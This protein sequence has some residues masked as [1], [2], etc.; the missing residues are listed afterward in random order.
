MGIGATY[1]VTFCH[2]RL[3]WVQTISS[4]YIAFNHYTPELQVEKGPRIYC[5]M[6]NIVELNSKAQVDNFTDSSSRRFRIM[7]RDSFVIRII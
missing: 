1:T 4:S 2:P 6:G 3:K 7:M 5:H